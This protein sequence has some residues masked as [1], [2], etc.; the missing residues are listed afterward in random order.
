[1]HL[2]GEQARYTSLGGV[3]LGTT[4]IAMLS[5]SVA[6]YSVAGRFHP[7]IIVAVPV[8]GL[9]V[10]SIDRWLISATW[11]GMGLRRLVPR[12]MLSIAIGLLVS[13]SLLLWV[14]G[15]AIKQQLITRRESA[16]NALASN[17]QFCNPVPGTPEASPP[18]SQCAEFHLPVTDA[19]LTP[20]L[21]DRDTTQA[22]ASQLQK[23]LNNDLNIYTAMVKV[24]DD[25]CTGRSGSGTSGVPG[26]GPRCK[27]LRAQADIYYTDHHIV[28]NSQQLAQLDSEAAAQ[29]KQIASKQTD[30]QARIAISINAY[31]AANKPQRP[32]GLIER[33]S[34]LGDLVARNNYAL[35]TEWAVRIFVITIDSMP[36]LLRVLTGRTAYDQLMEATQADEDRMREVRASADL[37]TLRREV[38]LQQRLRDRDD[39]E[40]VAQLQ[41]IIK[42]GIEEAILGPPLV[43]YDGWISVTVTDDEGAVTP[44]E[45]RRIGVEASRPIVL[46]V[47]IGPDRTADVAEPLVITQGIPRPTVDFL[48]EIDSDQ[49]SLRQSPILVTVDVPHGQAHARFS[50][51]PDVD[52]PGFSAWIWVRVSQGR[53]SL[54]SIELTTELAASRGRA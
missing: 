45:D 54:Q 12:L 4:I 7:I 50:L 23:T 22:Q 29:Q 18:R 17:L 36:V 10:L 20:L 46:E 40:Q 16:Y 1:V 25:E 21:L 11:R 42:S 5:M 53:R 39:P 41:N 52:E 2:P 6:L 3:V 31:L 43:N 15:S 34:A 13:E 9:F 47:T 33:Y 14:F 48:I 35:I 27:A 38:E 49:P 26:S 8:W 32:V 51:H 28:Q 24:A 30:T 37:A 44:S 19:G